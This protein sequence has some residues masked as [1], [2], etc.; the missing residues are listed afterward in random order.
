MASVT[1]RSAL[2]CYW[3]AGQTNCPSPFTQMARNIRALK[4]FVNKNYHIF[5]KIFDDIINFSTY[6][7][8]SNFVYKVGVVFILSNL[9]P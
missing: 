1:L 7:S 9:L 3:A 8:C 6:C 2:Y 5:T 4:F